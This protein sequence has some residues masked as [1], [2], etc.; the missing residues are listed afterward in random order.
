MSSM[1]H[2]LIHAAVA[3]LNKAFGEQLL[4]CMNPVPH[5]ASGSSLGLAIRQNLANRSFEPIFSPQDC[6]TVVVIV[7]QISM[8]EKAKFPDLRNFHRC[9]FR[10]HN[11]SNSLSY[12]VVFSLHSPLSPT[13]YLLD[14][15]LAWTI[16]TRG[17]APMKVGFSCC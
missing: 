15:L 11:T 4:F 8:T 2:K 1:E 7:S 14:S 16:K 10:Q 17:S 6:A 3:L 13:R 5:H 9:I 12:F